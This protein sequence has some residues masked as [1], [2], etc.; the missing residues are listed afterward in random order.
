VNAFV[1]Y[2]S[3][4]SFEM[5]PPLKEWSVRGLERDGEPVS[6]RSKEVVDTG[7]YVLRLPTAGA[8][9]PERSD[10][11]PQGIF[12][13]EYADEETNYLSKCSLAWLIVNTLDSPYRTRQAVHLKA[14]LD[15]EELGKLEDYEIK[16]AIRRHFTSCPLCLRVIK[17]E[18]LHNM[19][20]FDEEVGLGNASMQIVGATR[21][22]EVNLYH[23]I[24]LVYGVLQHMP[25]YVAW[26]HATCNTRLGQRIS[27]PLEQL[28]G[29]GMKV[30]IIKESELDTI[31]WISPDYQMIRSPLGAVWI[32]LCAD[33]TAAEEM[34]I[35]SHPDSE[36]A[37]DD[38]IDIGL[39][40]TL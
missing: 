18:Q 38:P 26:G 2:R 40:R 12:A 33:M 30:G 27:Y 21:S 36:I 14:I 1:L 17:Y 10:G 29:M 32:Q 39:T 31:G 19:V 11:P 23:L 22:T 28:K 25:K 7:H 8:N 34:G 15:K 24:P 6:E 13:P 5:L 3:Y 4:A 16:G 20:S 9:R 37:P 35:E